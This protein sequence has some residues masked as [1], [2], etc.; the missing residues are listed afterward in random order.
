MIFDFDAF[1]TAALFD[2]HGQA[3]FAL[4]DGTVRLQT[5]DG[6]VT[7]EAHDGAVL[8]ACVHPS[9]VGVLTGGDDGAVVWSRI[10]NG[11]VV[12]T[13]LA[14]VK[15]RWIEALAASPATGLIAFGAGKALH[16]L[17]TADAEFNRIYTHD[18]SISDIAF[19]PKGRRIAT[20]SYGGAHLWWARI[21]NQ[22]PQILK[23]AGSHIAVVW[24]PDGKFLISAMQENQLH[25][26]RLSDAKDMRMGG[27]PAKPRS[28][29]FFDGGKVL[30]T[31]GANGAV[32]W[33]FAG[34]N[35]PM[36]KEAAE[37]GF[38]RDSL[39]T[40]VAASLNG[41]V[42]AAGMSDGRVWAANLRS[43]RLE[44]LKAEK[45]AAISALSMSQ[46]GARLAFGDEAGSA[47]VLDV[48]EL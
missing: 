41:Q 37:I 8:S 9:G 3:A 39:S 30:A 43:G 1:T 46:D 23:W 42:V 5:Q 2:S 32:I 11:E 29:A 38:N 27:Y 36:G 15:S 7:V 35:G 34:A 20:A 18:K 25:G 44:T 10:E 17:D 21:E 26:W 14:Q 40:R 45:G 4:G 31:A 33:P 28:L 6:F 19:D 47:G 12:V 24:S 16:V 13:R 48:P 22:K